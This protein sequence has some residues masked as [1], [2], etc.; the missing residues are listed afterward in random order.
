MSVKG[1]SMKFVDL[2]HTFEDGMPGFC[3]ENADGTHT[4]YTAEV[5]PF[6]SHEESREKYDGKA[7][8]EVTEMRLQTSMRTYLDSPYHRHPEGRNISEIKISEL[9][10]PGT[11][12]AARGLDSDEKLTPDAFPREADLAGTAI[13]FNFGWDNN[14]GSER[15]RSYPYISEAIIERLMDTEVSLVGVNT[16]NADDY[17]NPARPTHTQLLKENIFIVENLRNLESLVGESL[18]LLK[19][20]AVDSLLRPC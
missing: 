10:L 19:S 8:F 17:Q 9:I 6:F 14:W 7:A 13:L 15:Y 18:A 11:V 4:E 3:H 20:S 16:L 12:V 1:N 2:S 5:S